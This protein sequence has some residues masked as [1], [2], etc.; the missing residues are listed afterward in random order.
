[1]KNLISKERYA[2]VKFKYASFFPLYGTHRGLSWAQYLVVYLIRLYLISSLPIPSHWDSLMI[3]AELAGLMALTQESK[4]DGKTWT[5]QNRI[6]LK[7]WNIL[8]ILLFIF[9]FPWTSYIFLSLL[10]SASSLVWLFSRVTSLELHRISALCYKVA[11]EATKIHAQ[12]IESLTVFCVFLWIQFLYASTGY[13]T[14]TW[15]FYLKWLSSSY[16]RH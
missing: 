1:M 8:Y 5:I 3:L 15:H 13:G 7:D 14:R 6:Q 12:E 11:A 9:L 10:Q 2:K 16:Y 4:T